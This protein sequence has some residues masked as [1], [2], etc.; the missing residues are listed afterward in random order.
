MISE[1]AGFTVSRVIPDKCLI[2]IMTGAYEICGGVIRD[3]SGQI[4]AHLINVVNPLNL[5]PPVNNALGA[6]NT[7]QLYKIGKDTSAILG[8]AKGTMLLSG[9]TLA[10]SAASFIFLYKKLGKID[11]KVTEIAKDVKKIRSFL[12]SKE[13]AAITTALKTLSGIVPS[14]DDKTRIPLL[15]NARQTL[16]EIHERYRDQLL[17]VSLVE[18]VL[19]IEEYYTITALGHAMCSAELDMLNN[20]VSDMDDAYETWLAASRRIST[21]LILRK[22]PERFI[23]SVYSKHVRTDEI[24]DWMNFANGANKGT[25]WVDELRKNMSPVRFPQIKV[26]NRDAIELEVIR[27]FSARNRI[28]SGYTSQ[29]RYL[30]SINQ[31]P[32]VVQAYFDSLSANYRVEDCH[33]LI[34][35]AIR[36]GMPSL[37][38]D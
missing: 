9:L 14:L 23:F 18:E 5:M 3:N 25:E 38:R 30:K 33:I 15:V 24:I 22:D 1:L 37:G 28:Y 12:E 19:P 8:L 29:Y 31:R 26:S 35:D 17:G 11:E 7:F 2:G 13:K 6:L 20:A 34:A 32:S 10:V 27:K 36:N 16:G 21:D 4:V